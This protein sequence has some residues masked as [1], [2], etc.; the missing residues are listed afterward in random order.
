MVI[1]PRQFK[2]SKKSEQKTNHIKTKLKWYDSGRLV[3]YSTLA[4]A[5]ATV[6][7]A[8]M[9]WLHV[10]KTGEMIKVN[11]EQFK[12]VS[13]PTIVITGHP[14]AK[15]SSDFEIQLSNRGE[16]TAFN[17]STMI[18][19]LYS[20]PIKTDSGIKIENNFRVNIK[21]EYIDGSAFEPSLETYNSDVSIVSYSLFPK[22]TSKNFGTF[23]VDNDHTLGNLKNT[24]VFARFLVPYD[25]KYRY[26]IRT[27]SKGNDTAWNI[28][29]INAK[30][31]LL[32]RFL[33]YKNMINVESQQYQIIDAF[34]VD[35]DPRERPFNQNLN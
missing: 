8:I 10:Q 28:M 2:P 18:V 31:E 5:V 19:H 22:I 15:L 1:K 29:G 26:Q 23:Y 25:K 6:A 16:I 11:Q 3:A 33:N 35:F 12:L 4:L 17:F 32:K 7:M 13:Y 14:A 20:V 21:A 9:T 27:F 34:L 30:N 24:I